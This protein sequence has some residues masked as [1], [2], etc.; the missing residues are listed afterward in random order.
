MAVKAPGDLATAAVR[1]I[2]PYVPGKPVSELERELGLS[3]IVKLASNENPLG[4]SPRALQ[5]MRAALDESWVYPDG[6]GHALK[7]ALHSALGVAPDC[8]TLG[9]GSNDVLVLLAEAFL[10]PQD[11]AIYSQYAFAVYPIAVQATGAK[12]VVV[13]ALAEDHPQM[14]L[15]HDLQA[16]AAAIGARTRLIFIANPNNPTGTWLTSSALRRFLH[17]VP[18]TTLVVL[19]EA[20]FEYALGQDLGDGLAWLKE[21]PQ[22]VIV[23][24]FSKAYGLAGLRLGFAAAHPSVSDVLNRLRQSFN[25]N[26]LALAAGVEALRDVQHVEQARQCVTAGMRQ[27]QQALPALKVSAVPSA[28]NFLLLRIGPRAAAVYEFMLHQGVIVRPVANYGLGSWL[29]VTIGTAA[30]NERAISALSAALRAVGA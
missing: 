30:Q 5:A 29:R 23:R 15:G 9:N 22:L 4:P 26:L 6:S 7:Q 13:P 25:V 19:D 8:L 11:E 18:S 2:S 17:A 27:W 28:G 12:A 20:Y 14:P 24:T 10:T 16:M 3:G 1:A 21:F